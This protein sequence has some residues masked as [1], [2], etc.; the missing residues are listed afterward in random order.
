MVNKNSIRLGWHDKIHCNFYQ[1]YT[2][3]ALKPK[4]AKS[5]KYL[6]MF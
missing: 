6:G 4:M 3:Y 5:E 2:A 1:C